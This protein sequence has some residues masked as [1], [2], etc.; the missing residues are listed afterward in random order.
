MFSTTSQTG[1]HTII[2]I[3]CQAYGKYTVTSE[4]EKWTTR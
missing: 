4:N 2:D 3:Y 1:S